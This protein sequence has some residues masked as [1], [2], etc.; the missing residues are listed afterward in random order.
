M[1]YNKTPR[2]FKYTHGEAVLI[3][4]I[5]ENGRFFSSIE[6]NGTVYARDLYERVPSEPELNKQGWT[7]EYE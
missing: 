6:K 1:Q 4:G 2:K 7:R 5:D 3:V